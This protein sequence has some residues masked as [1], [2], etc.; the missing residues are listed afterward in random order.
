MFICTQIVTHIVT[1]VLVVLVSSS[2]G[3]KAPTLLQVFA[4]LH[5]EHIHFE[6]M[7]QST[8]STAQCAADS[9]LS[10]P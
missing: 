5:F 8:G 3:Q 1:H 2:L 4:D 6:H 9:L 7:H 10:Q